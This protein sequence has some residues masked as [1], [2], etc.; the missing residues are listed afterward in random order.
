MAFDYKNPEIPKLTEEFKKKFTIDI[1]GKKA[2]KVDGLIAFA[3]TKGIK[4]MVTEVTQYPSQENNFT[5][6]AKCRVVGYGWNP[7]EQ[8]VSEVVFEDFADANPNNCTSM[9]AAAYP[10]M[11]S[12]RAQGRALRRYTNI[13]MVTSEEINETASDNNA[14]AVQR[15][16][17]GQLTMIKNIIQS[18]RIP[19]AQCLQL[20][21]DKY[22]TQD[23]QTLTFDQAN[24][25]A[26][27]LG[28]LPD[29]QSA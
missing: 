24:E 28:S 10:R 26:R 8:K 17:I 20:L 18:K 22:N 11:A 19:Q 3:H 9:T 15:A 4:S 6:I 25:I 1:R 21:K 2:I 12:T 16:N 29:P 13:D 7:I 14:P 23:F 5:C 27:I